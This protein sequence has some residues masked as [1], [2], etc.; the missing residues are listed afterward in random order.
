MRELYTKLCEKE[1]LIPIFSQPWWLDMVC[2]IQKWDVALV[3]KNG[4]IL[5]AMPYYISRPNVMGMPPLTQTLG[6]WFRQGE[7]SYTKM[8]SSQMRLMDT[9]IDQLPKTKQFSQKFNYSITNWLPFYWRG[10]EQTTHY[11]YVI[12]D[13]SSETELWKNLEGKIR[14]DIKKAQN[15]FGVEVKTNLPDS[16]FLEVHSKTFERQKMR[17]PNSRLVESILKKSREKNMGKSFFAVDQEGVIHAVALLVWNNASA[18]YLLGSGDSKLRKSGA[19][20]LLMWEMIK[21]SSTVTS[22]FDFEGSMIKP[23]EKHFRAYGAKQC[24]YF[25]IYFDH[26]NFAER[27]L[28]CTKIKMSQI[29]CRVRGQK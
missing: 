4:V 14:T 19:Q 17:P 13:L 29:Y 7:G 10:F 8:L 20:S 28:A 21:F 5:A 1:P 16:Q 18:Y 24:P 12:D 9:L 6:P 15:R 11:T 26:R 27:L 22:R 25:R 2:G 3:E 23:I